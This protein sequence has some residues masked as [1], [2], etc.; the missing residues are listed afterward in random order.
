M[1][2]TAWHSELIAYLRAVLIWLFREQACAI[3]E[4]LNFYRTM[5]RMEYP[6]APDLAVIKGV[7]LEYVRSWAPGRIDIPPHVVFEILSK[8]TWKKDLREK[9]IIYAD[10]GVREFFAYDPHE[11][12]LHRET[13]GRL[14]GWRLDVRSGRMVA[15]TFSKEGWL[16]SEQ[17]NSWLVPE[18]IHLR[19]YD[20]E[21]RVRLTGEE[22]QTLLAEVAAERASSAEERV[23]ELAEQA[24]EAR[25]AEEEARQAEA[26]ARKQAE[27]EARRAQEAIRRAEEEAQRAQALAETLRSLGIDPD[28]L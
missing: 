17:L 4:N 9:P 28:T 2:E 27:E 13:A 1:G 23:A 18:G 14:F 16:W 5:D 6:I 7:Q 3:Y 25:R 26:D 10:M 24:E 15:M 20:R 22:A 8:E 19:L 12:P 21:G 11:P